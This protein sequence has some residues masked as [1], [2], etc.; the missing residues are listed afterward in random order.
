M[1]KELLSILFIP[2]LTGLFLVVVHAFFGQIILRRGIVFLDLA[3]AQ[4]ASLGY[5]S[6]EY[7]G[8]I[9]HI[10]IIANIPPQVI[11]VISVLIP[12]I[13]LVLLTDNETRKLLE[14]IIAML[15]AFSFSLSVLI[16]ENIPGGFE[17]IKETFLGSL[18]TLT[19]N[20][21]KHLLLLYLP[22]LIINL[23]FYKKYLHSQTR[24]SLDILFYFSLGLVVT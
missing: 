22:I 4:F 18:V 1:S 7:L 10:K 2:S 6:F 19:K 9:K 24:R 23:F 8:H 14:G 11:S 12:A 15:Y 16:V 20:D 5:L 3:M 13:L 21:L 17:V